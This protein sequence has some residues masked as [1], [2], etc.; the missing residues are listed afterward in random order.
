MGYAGALH[1]RDSQLKPSCTRW[2]LRSLVINPQHLSKLADE[3][4]VLQPK[5][6]FRAKKL[7][8]SCW[9]FVESR[10]I[11]FRETNF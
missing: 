4:E 6:Y 10:D 2:N 3:I 8:K 5:S 1:V 7:L 11:I 9:K